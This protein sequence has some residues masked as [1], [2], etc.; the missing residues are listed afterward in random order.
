MVILTFF[1]WSNL[2]IEEF[3][4]P[5]APDYLTSTGTIFI[6]KLSLLD[7][8]YTSV[9]DEAFEKVNDTTIV[10][11]QWEFLIDTRDVHVPYSFENTYFTINPIG[12][13]SVYIDMS[14]SRAYN[15]TSLNSILAVTLHDVSSK[16]E[17]TEIY[18]YPHMSL[19]FNPTRNKFM[20]QADLI[21]VSSVFDIDYDTQPFFVENRSQDLSV[22]F[23]N[24]SDILVQQQV[25]HRQQVSNIDSFEV[26]SFPGVK[27]IQQYY[28][29]FVN[30][31]K[32]KIY[33]K[34]MV[35]DN[36]LQ[37]TQSPTKNTLLIE[38]VYENIQKLESY[39]QE[40]QEVRDILDYIYL[41]VSHSYDQ[42][43]TYPK[44]NLSYL[45]QK[46][47][48]KNNSDFSSDYISSYILDSLYREYDYTNVYSYR[49]LNSFFQEYIQ[50]LSV[51]IQTLETSESSDLAYLEYFS[52]FIENIILSRFEATLENASGDLL[53]WKNLDDILQVMQGY[54]SLN[55]T[56]YSASNS[57]KALSLI[58]RY[59]NVL[60]NLEQFLWRTFFLPERNIDAL[61][62]KNSQ[63]IITQTVLRLFQENTDQILDFYTQGKRFLDTQKQRDI[64]ITQEYEDMLQIFPE[65][66]SALENYESY[67][68]NY[69]TEKRNL[70]DV[71]TFSDNRN[72]VLSRDNF[73][74]YMSQF[75]LLSLDSLQLEIV[76][77]IYYK[78]SGIFIEGKEFSFHLYPFTDNQIDTI[79]I[80]GTAINSSYKLD[81]IEF[82]WA[83]RIQG[84][85]GD[86]KDTYDFSLFFSNTFLVENTVNPDIFVVEK[87]TIQEDPVIIVF[88]RDRLLWRNGEFSPVQ[89]FL[90]IQYEDLN[91]VEGNSW[92]DI[93]LE[94]TVA[95]LSSFADFWSARDLSAYFSSDYI[96]S[97]TKHQF[98]DIVLDLFIQTNQIQTFPLENI[99]IEFIGSIDLQDLEKVLTEFVASYQN[100]VYTYNVIQREFSL[101]NISIKYSIFNSKLTI[102]FDYN[103][104]KITIEILWDSLERV[105]KGNTVIQEQSLSYRELERIILQIKN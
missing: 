19:T 92:Y 57:A 54:I 98:R 85:S 70:L 14:D 2:G 87:S 5:Q 102:K 62:V 74:E 3:T 41:S 25:Y 18:L 61:L 64:F 93:S 22:F 48:G 100:L 105:S 71:E 35:L 4:I 21:R 83:E 72:I 81:N 32:K 12:I 38:Q 78:A 58:Y 44:I 86:E 99:P 68:F 84:I 40:L 50:E 79:T 20:K 69:N 24:V 7:T 76:D 37:L 16:E 27:Y 80:N 28:N 101:E 10:L 36:I 1:Q 104:E 26:W 55:N 34:N 42:R 90:N 67:V 33:Y 29:I 89:D 65:Y 88:K 17:I 82:L 11:Q 53:I 39:P 15:I 66:F 49:T 59:I 73:L 94:N 43:H 52:F 6:D 51:D 31:E 63:N 91:V 77:D 30:E 96:L 13:G 97:S 23:Q 8:L 9:E 103:N 75:R 95:S 47:K 46:L 56:I 45:Q 60:Q